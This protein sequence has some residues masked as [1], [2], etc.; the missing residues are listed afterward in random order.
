MTD[1]SLED[2]VHERVPDDEDERLDDQEREEDE[3]DEVDEEQERVEK[4]A[5]DL[6]WSPEDEWRGDPN[7]WA[8]ASVYLDR[9]AG[10][11][12]FMDQQ[13]EK[14]ERAYRETIA[15]LE[16]TIKEQGEVLGDLSERFTNAD[17]A[18]FARG[19]KAARDEMAAAV[20]EGDTE[21]YRAAEQ[22]YDDLQ[23]RGPP[24]PKKKEPPPEERQDEQQPT[25]DPA[26]IAWVQQ[27]PWYER[28][29]FLRDVAVAASNR[30]A[31]EEPEL[32]IAE[33]LEK[34]SA[35]IRRRFPERFENERRRAPSA[36]N[37][38]TGERAPRNKG[39]RT[40]ANLPKEAKAACDK[41]VRTIPGF[42]KEQYIETYDGEWM[43]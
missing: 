4:E 38:K 31:A 7:K 9:M 17:K 33:N 29:R 15:K 3:H 14:M 43:E 2:R 35:E 6:G 13:F 39:K 11:R 19:L 25:I 22:R 18:A 41:Y 34:V 12:R 36:V 32:T 10:N 1:Q 40:Y 30:I 23:E 27:N 42:T 24:E 20:A 5:R 21:R 28:D 8:P 26:V 37:G 16:G